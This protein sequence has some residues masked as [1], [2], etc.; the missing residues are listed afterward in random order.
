M[1][2]IRRDVAESANNARRTKRTET[3]WLQDSRWEMR[4]V[5]RE[6]ER[7]KKRLYC[8]QE[9]RAK[10]K[11]SR[12]LFT[13]FIN[14]HFCGRK[15]S[16]KGVDGRAETELRESGREKSRGERGYLVE[17]VTRNRA[18]HKSPGFR[19]RSR[20]RITHCEKPSSLS[21]IVIRYSSPKSYPS[22]HRSFLTEF[23]EH[24]TTF[25]LLFPISRIT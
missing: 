15:S 19:R 4:N 9:W 25:A 21:E 12:S 22:A 18:G 17:E 13:S 16:R 14:I 11:L 20:L 1:R 2:H 5:Q 23:E 8:K 3:M 7:G 10:R 24:W 6:R